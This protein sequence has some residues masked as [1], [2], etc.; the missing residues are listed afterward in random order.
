MR[1]RARVH[2]FCCVSCVFGSVLYFVCVNVDRE[3]LGAKVLRVCF[4]FTREGVELNRSFFAGREQPH[5]ENFQLQD[6]AADSVPAYPVSDR[7]RD[8]SLKH[9]RK[10]EGNR[11]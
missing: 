5:D 2:V 6:R 9:D 4:S 10:T 7:I 8:T 3:T 11:L 1:A